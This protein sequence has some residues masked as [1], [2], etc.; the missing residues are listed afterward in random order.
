[1][2]PMQVVFIIISIFS[3]LIV[4]YIY[5]YNLFQA[6]IIR[7]NEVEA[8]IDDL[9]RRKYEL[10]LRSR[11]IIKGTND[12]KED[13]MKYLDKLKTKNLTSFE[14]D[15]ELSVGLNEFYKIR[16]VYPEV[17]ESDGFLNINLE[18]EDIEE[19]IIACRNYYN[20]NITK[21]NKLVKTFPSNIIGMVIKAK[22]KTFY[23]GKNLY[24]SI[25]NDFKL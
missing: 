4:F 3:L 13:V 24:D 16:E 25:Y 23:D 20:D 18:L 8:D 21:F 5:Y 7:I 19:Q 10:L 1:M 6:S 15:Q 2:E 17:K 22:E 9:L 14:F 11:D 12:I